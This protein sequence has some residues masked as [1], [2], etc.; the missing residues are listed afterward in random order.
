MV[1]RQG[2]EWVRNLI[3]WHPGVL[4]IVSGYFIYFGGR[5]IAPFYVSSVLLVVFLFDFPLSL[6]NSL[7]ASCRCQKRWRIS[8]LL[9]WLKITRHYWSSFS[10]LVADSAEVFNNLALALLTNNYARS[11]RFN[12]RTRSPLRKKETRFSKNSLLS[13]RIV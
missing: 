10:K 9:L 7:V 3:F 4:R 1:E 5:W 12:T 8:V 13:F 2:N 11:R 6:V